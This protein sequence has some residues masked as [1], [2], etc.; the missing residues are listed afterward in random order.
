M[1]D[2][3]MPALD[4]NGGGIRTEVADSFG[5]MYPEDNL[6]WETSLEIYFA[7]KP[8]AEARK[9]SFVKLKLNSTAL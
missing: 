3:L 7:W 2:C 8:M 6:D 9:E 5:K 4:L 1:E